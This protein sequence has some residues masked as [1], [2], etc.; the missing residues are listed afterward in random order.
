MLVRLLARAP[1]RRSPSHLSCWYLASAG[2]PLASGSPKGPFAS[3]DGEEPNQPALDEEAKQPANEI[4][5]SSTA[6]GAEAFFMGHIANIGEN[7]SFSID[8]S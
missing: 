4:A 3:L 6:I 7:I 5:I 8:H 1:S 2:P